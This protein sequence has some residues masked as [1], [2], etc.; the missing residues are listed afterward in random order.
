MYHHTQIMKDVLQKLTAELT[1]LNRYIESISTI[2]GGTGLNLSIPTMRNLKR[3][4][5]HDEQFEKINPK[6]RDY[7]VFQDILNVDVEM[8][9]NLEDFFK[10]RERGQRLADIHRMTPELAYR[11][12]QHFIIDPDGDESTPGGTN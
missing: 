6:Y 1:K 12:H 10:H 4:I 3:I 9:V 2:S 5:S 8:A 11:I 7:R